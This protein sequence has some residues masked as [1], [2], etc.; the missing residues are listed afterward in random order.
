MEKANP[1]V[2]SQEASRSQ[3][4][5]FLAPWDTSQAKQANAAQQGQQTKQDGQG[6]EPREANSVKKKHRSRVLKTNAKS[7]RRKHSPTFI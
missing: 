5:L 3:S 6:K 7:T 2:S 1:E 4:R